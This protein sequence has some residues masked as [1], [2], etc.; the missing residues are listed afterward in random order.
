MLIIGKCAV[1]RRKPT[2]TSFSCNSHVSSSATASALS[3]RR[4][5]SRADAFARV[6]CNDVHRRMTCA[7]RSP[8]QGG[9]A[10][11]QQRAGTSTDR[12]RSAKVGCYLAAV[13]ALALAVLGLAAS[14]FAF[15]RRALVL[16]LAPNPDPDRVP[17]PFV[18]CLTLLHWRSLA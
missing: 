14:A 13:G 16:N 12:W 6:H 15:G 10:Q 7:Q 9:A 17:G 2:S 18:A 1:S 5:V 4:G 8:L 3:A 11:W